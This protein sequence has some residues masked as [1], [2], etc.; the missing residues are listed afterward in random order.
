MASKRAE[1]SNRSK[2]STISNIVTKFSFAT[3][4]GV[5]PHKPFKTNQDAFLTN[6]HMIQTSHSHFFSV[7][8]G[9]GHNGHDVSGLLKKR[10]ALNIEQQLR[11]K[12]KNLGDDYPDPEL[13]EACLIKGFEESNKEIYNSGIDIRFSGSTCVSMLTYG[14]KLYTANVGDSR[15]IMVRAQ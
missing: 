1:S 15:A 6:P 11:S 5:A 14:R 4:G 13:M 12:L 3:K 9:H 8:D 10:L 7:C 2:P